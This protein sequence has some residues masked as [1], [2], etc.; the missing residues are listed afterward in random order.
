[1]PRFSRAEDTITNLLV[2]WE[3]LLSRHSVFALILYYPDQFLLL[4][5]KLQSCL[6]VCLFIKILDCELTVAGFFTSVENLVIMHSVITNFYLEHAD[7]V[8]FFICFCYFKKVYPGNCERLIIVFT[9]ARSFLCPLSGLQGFG[10]L[11][12]LIHLF[13]HFLHSTTTTPLLCAVH[14]VYCWEFSVEKIQPALT[15]N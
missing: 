9:R 14:H 1:M 15:W 10:V 2:R 13:I 4:L 6:F 5:L 8:S 12:L 3:L 7:V 11:H